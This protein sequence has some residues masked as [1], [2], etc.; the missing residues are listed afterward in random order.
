MESQSITT[1][2]QPK[3]LLG[4]PTPLA[5]HEIVDMIWGSG[6]IPKDPKLALEVPLEF[7]ERWKRYPEMPWPVTWHESLRLM[8]TSL[9]QWLAFYEMGQERKDA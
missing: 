9:K 4:P 7:L 8:M 6:A 3:A 2:E 1:S 5:A